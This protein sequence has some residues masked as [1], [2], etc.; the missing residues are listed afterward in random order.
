MAV[1]KHTHKKSKETQVEWQNRETN[2][3]KHSDSKEI[4]NERNRMFTRHTYFPKR[5]LE[6][7]NVNEN[8]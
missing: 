2:G 3:N 4:W 5:T 1:Q 8:K 7:L 6:I